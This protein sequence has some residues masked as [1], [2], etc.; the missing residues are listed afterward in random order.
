MENS[1]AACLISSG[2]IE[3]AGNYDYIEIDTLLSQEEDPALL[4]Q[5]GRR[6]LPI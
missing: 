6:I 2:D 5:S 4:R 3:I 1:G